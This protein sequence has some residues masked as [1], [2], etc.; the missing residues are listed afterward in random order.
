MNKYVIANSHQ[1]S[2]P[3]SSRIVTCF[4]RAEKFQRQLLS[5]RLSPH[6]I[7]VDTK[8]E[9]ESK[10]FDR[11]YLCVL[12]FV[13]FVVSTHIKFNASSERQK[14]IKQRTLSG[15]T[16]YK[17]RSFCS[18]SI[19]ANVFVRWNE[20]FTIII[21]IFF[22][23]NFSTIFVKL[24]SNFHRLLFENYPFG[25]VFARIHYQFIYYSSF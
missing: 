24:H 13:V 2:K 22:N 23:Q 17:H 3:L 5:E 9:R 12:Q 6:R 1:K 11:F 19:D 10:T 15:Q 18:I 8:G 20:T 16:N 4:G 25:T 21:S 14:W 7:V